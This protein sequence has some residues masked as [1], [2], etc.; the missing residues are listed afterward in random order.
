MD[1]NAGSCATV[2]Y[3]PRV[4][5]CFSLLLLS[6]DLFSR[7]LPVELALQEGVVPPPVYVVRSQADVEAVEDAAAAAVV[8]AAVV[9]A[10]VA[11]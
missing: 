7:V 8:A 10:G 2:R 9:A 1:S 4:F 6:S 5:A 3:I 11:G